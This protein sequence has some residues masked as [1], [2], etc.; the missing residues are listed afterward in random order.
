MPTAVERMINASTL[1]TLPSALTSPKP[2][3][4]SRVSTTSG[5]VLTVSITVSTGRPTT[6]DRTSSASR[7]LDAP[8]RSMSPHRPRDGQNIALVTVNW[9]SRLANVPAADI[10]L[11]DSVS[12]VPTVSG[13]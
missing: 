11:N 4:N 2:E 12:G 3:S 7:L 5:C 1:V 10:S 13:T 9:G 8:S 6:F